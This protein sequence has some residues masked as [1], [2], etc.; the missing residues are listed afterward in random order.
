M[1]WKSWGI[2]NSSRRHAAAAASE[3]R[4][5]APAGGPAMH[6]SIARSRG[7]RAPR[8]GHGC[9]LD[10]RMDAAWMRPRAETCGGARHATAAG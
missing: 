6:A 3:L 5:G 8:H 7:R 10:D 9:C 1:I 4:A 2:P